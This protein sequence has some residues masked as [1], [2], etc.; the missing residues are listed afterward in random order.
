MRITL[1]PQFNRDARRFKEIVQVL[2]KYGQFRFFLGY[3]V[4]AVSLAE[5]FDAFMALSYLL[6][7]DTEDVGI[8]QGGLPGDFGILDG[9][10][11]QAYH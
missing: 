9:C 5:G 3:Q 4:L 11:H 10:H 2:L 7:D 1:L 6:G 8:S